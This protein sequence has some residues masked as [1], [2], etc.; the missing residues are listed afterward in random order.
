MAQNVVINGEAQL[1]GIVYEEIEVIEINLGNGVDAVTVVDTSY[2]MHM[3][4]L[5]KDD[6]SV[7]VHDISGP[8]IIHGREG[9][10]AVTVESEEGKLDK[11]QALLAFDGGDEDEGSDTLL[12]NNT[13]DS[14]TDDVWNVTRFV[15]EVASMD[16]VA[17][18]SMAPFVSYLLNFQ[19]ATG[20]TFT[21][22]VS[23]PIENVPKSKTLTYPVAG[24][25]YDSAALLE[26][27]IQRLVIP[28]EDELDTC[29]ELG[30]SKC[31]SAVK[32]FPVGDDSF[33]VFFVGER[34]KEDIELT[35]STELTGFSSEMFLNETN[36]IIKQNSDICYSNLEVLEIY[37]GDL[38]DKVLNIRGTFGFVSILPGS[39]DAV[40]CRFFVLSSKIQ[41][42]R[43]HESVSL[44]LSGTSASSMTTI[45]T[46]TGDEFVF[47]SSE[48]NE[49]ISTASTMDHLL[50]WLDYVEH[51]LTIN[52][53][54]GR[55]RLL[56]SDERSEIAKG[57]ISPDSVMTLTKNSLTQIHEAVGD[58]YFNSQGNWSAGVDL[59][60]G[61]GDDRLDVLSVPSNPGSAP[62]RTTTSVH[63]GHG[64]DELMVALDTLQHDGVVFVANG[65]FGDDTINC[66][67]STHPVILFGGRGQDVLV[68]GE[69]DDI[70]FGDLGRVYW[71]ESSAAN[72]FTEAEGKGAIKAVAGGKFGTHD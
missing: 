71:R 2:A 22:G 26:S 13:A 21:L 1:D 43:A 31:A 61:S 41:Y 28:K 44:Y 6:D 52:T 63:A 25:K 16:F 67:Q 30:T 39:C 24:N 42:H 47:I 57:R 59:W 14:D 65:Q 40:S 17:N 70:I 69:S 68:G 49:N 66:S 48:A 32:V 11:I 7:L 34:L 37:T 51:D 50:G 56:M 8:F 27:T 64:D 4:D 3:L 29:G 38:D 19:S 35:L 36:D 9:S 72:I 46:Q 5:G 15:V 58:I 60:L 12:L 18:S 62:F 20:G 10:D 53:D 55:H 33:V 54:T 45:H 23:D